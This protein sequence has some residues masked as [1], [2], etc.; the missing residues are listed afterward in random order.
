MLA[1]LTALE[2]EFGPTRMY[3]IHRDLRFARSKEPFKTEIGGAVGARGGVGHIYMDARKF[4][5]ASGLYMAMPDQQTRFLAAIN[6]ERSGRKLERIVVELEAKTYRVWSAGQL[7]N[8]PKGY[9]SVHPRIRFLRMKGIVA[10]REF[11]HM[12]WVNTSVVVER[13]AEVFRDAGPLLDWLAS[14]VGDSSMSAERARSS[15]S[16]PLTI[17]RG[18]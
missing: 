15:V 16:V 11:G 8:A 3:R 18:G 12:P 1:L 4:Y 5:A 13:V 9:P 17:G 14:N 2:K 10:S 7:K 6:A